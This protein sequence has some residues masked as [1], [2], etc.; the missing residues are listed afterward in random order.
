MTSVEIGIWLPNPEGGDPPESFPSRVNVANVDG[1]DFIYVP[2][3]CR[4]ADANA[5][6]GFAALVEAAIERAAFAAST[7]DSPSDAGIDADLSESPFASF[8]PT[9]D[10]R[11]AYPGLNPSEYARPPTAR[12]QK[13]VANIVAEL[14]HSASGLD[15]PNIG[16]HIFV[17]FVLGEYAGNTWGRVTQTFVADLLPEIT[18][19]TAQPQEQTGLAKT[20]CKN[21]SRFALLL[22]LKG[23]DDDGGFFASDSYSGNGDDALVTSVLGYLGINASPYGHT[24]FA[25]YIGN[26]TRMDKADEGSN[27]KWTNVFEKR[28]APTSS[29]FAGIWLAHL[30]AF[31]GGDESA[32]AAVVGGHDLYDIAVTNGLQPFADDS[33][34][35]IRFNGFLF[36]SSALFLS[37]TAPFGLFILDG[38]YID[39]G[40]TGKTN[41]LK[42]GIAHQLC[43]VECSYSIEPNIDDATN[44][45][46]GSVSV[47]YL[48]ELKEWEF[49]N[50]TTD[51]TM[52]WSVSATTITSNSGTVKEMRHQEID[53]AAYVAHELSGAT[54]ESTVESDL[55]ELGFSELW[56]HT[57]GQGGISWSGGGIESDYTSFTVIG[58]AIESTTLLSRI[59]DNPDL[60]NEYASTVGEPILSST[61]ATGKVSF[62]ASV[63]YDDTS[64]HSPAD[65]AGLRAFPCKGAI[66]FGY[67][68]SPQMWSFWHGSVSHSGVSRRIYA[69]P[70][71]PYTLDSDADKLAAKDG[72]DFIENHLDA[73]RVTAESAARKIINSETCLFERNAIQEHAKEL[74]RTFPTQETVEG[75]VTKIDG[76][77]WGREPSASRFVVFVYLNDNGSIARIT[78]AELYETTTTEYVDSGVTLI[79]FVT[80]FTKLTVRESRNTARLGLDLASVYEGVNVYNAWS[81]T[82]KFGGCLAAFDWAWKAIK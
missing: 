27:Y 49:D 37:R 19:N 54:G 75:A 46:D 69:I 17:P 55:K 50:K 48:T 70:R 15:Q 66:S 78:G 56:K 23:D 8:I 11:A 35:G 63:P 1:V 25:Y 18:E 82:L 41:R 62:S 38:E 67:T 53:V 9:P 2:G 13:A 14:R 59:L 30:R 6:R 77:E 4:L 21:L 40:S 61:P 7:G 74:R 3:L 47:T 60:A 42:G 76:G 26:Q 32:T 24:P 52:N 65:M 33:A 28:N 29:D 43:A 16:L 58:A 71:K 57:K 39:S 22:P 20:I 45:W 44:T 72:V 5:R 10:E 51:G 73:A 80:G 68:A 36:A 79:E 31:A 64:A 34:A 81:A 12:W